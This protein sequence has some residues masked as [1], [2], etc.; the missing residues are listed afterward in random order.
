MKKKK[1][2]EANLKTMTN[3]NGYICRE[4]VPDHVTIIPLPISNHTLK[5]CI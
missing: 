4:E 5:P 3:F 1:K 2:K